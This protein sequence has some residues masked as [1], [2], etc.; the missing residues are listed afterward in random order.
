M[1]NKR[2]TLI[3]LLVVI[4]IIAILAAIL[5][6]ALQ[7]ARQRGKDSSCINILKQLGGATGM[8]ANDYDDVLVP[9]RAGG[10]SASSWC[11][12]FSKGKYV[13]ELC[14]R[15][16]P[17]DGKKYPAP[18]LCPSSEAYLNKIKT[19]SSSN[20]VWKAYD[21][22]G[23]VGDS[24]QFGGYGRHQYMGGYYDGSFRSTFQ[25]IAMF[26]W[27][28]KKWNFVDATL[29]Q[30]PATIG[31]YYSGTSLNTGSTN[32][33]LWIAH[34]RGV[35]YTGVDGH[36]ERVAFTE[37][38]AVVAIVDGT[39]MTAQHYYWDGRYYNSSKEAAVD[40]L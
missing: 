24:W 38:K 6:P 5:L 33:I 14:D 17:T 19:R 12:L 13:S 23:T 20:T 9:N 26:R 29:Y 18:P 27:P 31:D 30:M 15:Y 39:G 32:G 21:L 7:K 22:D 10:K 40:T 1:K 2:F 16:D 34:H 11:G 4:A 3:E 36:V 35:N 28:S 8:Y 37:K 25:K